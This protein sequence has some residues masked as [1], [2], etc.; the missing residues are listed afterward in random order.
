MTEIADQRVLIFASFRKDAELAVGA[1]DHAG[2]SSFAC[3]TLPDLMHELDEGAGVV[4][5]VEEALPPAAATPLADFVSHQPTWSDLPILVLT[6]PG[7]GSEWLRGAYDRLGNLT[8]LERPVHA[9]TLVSAVR[10]ALRARLK[11]Y[12]VRLADQRKDEFLAMLAH[13]LRNPL[14][15]I[16]AAAQFL[17]LVASD[18]D[19]VKQ[20]SAIISRQVAHMS[21]LIDDLLDLA[22]VTRNLINLVKEPLDV[23]KILS[24][25]VEQ[26]GPLVRA[27][28]HHLTLHLPPGPAK[29]LGDHKRLVQIIV[30]LLNNA[31]KYT[32]DGG[33]IALQL[34]TPTGEVAV[35]VTDDGIGMAPELVPRVFD[36]FSQAERSS[37]R[38]QGGLGLGLPLVKNLAELHGGSVLAQSDG[39]GKGSKF[40]V[41][42]PQLAAASAMP[43][44]AHGLGE[45]HASAGRPLRVLV[46][47]DNVDAANTLHMLLDASGHEVFTEY[48][49]ARA[50]ERTQE[51]HPQV[52][53]LDIGLP[54]MDGCELARR[55]RAL[56]AMANATLI[57]ISGYGQEQDKQRSADAG[58][59]F[60]LVKPI[61]TGKLLTL[62]AQAP[63]V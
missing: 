25:A 4:L 60:H 26:V 5:T 18:P 55:L 17:P 57:A 50:I 40:T 47:D 13:E 9:S 29:V 59:D 1:L 23:R 6:K 43:T 30:N 3:K 42:F 7:G 51:I 39:V 58:F 44:A 14:A 11:Q 24:E 16:G 32:P 20:A 56:P 41:R 21:S 10:G 48:T 46:V 34:R 38:S 8:L 45:Q 31:A 33:H 62:L 15:P 12:Q 19:K 49:A 22:R 28:H 37:D 2:F 52:C 54:D 36:L 35:E 53:L 27:R 63:D 61:N